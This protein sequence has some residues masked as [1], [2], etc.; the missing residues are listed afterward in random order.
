M[1]ANLSPELD[2]KMMGGGRPSAFL[3]MHGKSAV[4]TAI[5]TSGICGNDTHTGLRLG[6]HNMMIKCT[7]D[8]AP[9]LAPWNPLI[10]VVPTL[11]T[12]PG[13]ALNVSSNAKM[14]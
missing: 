11:H 1:S 2:E 13:Y 7:V 12:C 6:K 14:I 3:W 8:P 4:C 10:P 5:S 9:H